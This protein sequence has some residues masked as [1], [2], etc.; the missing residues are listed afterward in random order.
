MN[1]IKMGSAY[2]QKERIKGYHLRE[3]VDKDGVSHWQVRA[4][5]MQLR[6]FDSKLKAEEYL[7]Y[8]IGRLAGDNENQE[9]AD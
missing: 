2:F 8:V 4:D 6:I 5:T 3:I 7:D 9:T 1:Y